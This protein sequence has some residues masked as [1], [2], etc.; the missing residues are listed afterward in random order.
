MGV[1]NPAAPRAPLCCCLS[2]PLLGKK[3]PKIPVVQ[4]GTGTHC[5]QM[6]PTLNALYFLTAARDW[7]DRKERSR[8]RPILSRHKILLVKDIVTTIMMGRQLIHC[9]GDKR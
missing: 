2:T 9:A 3:N 5:S 6:L 1:P 7:N 8:K 4:L